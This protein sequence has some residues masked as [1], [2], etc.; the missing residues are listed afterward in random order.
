MGGIYLDEMYVGRMD[1]F[2]LQF[3]LFLVFYLGKVV[4]ELYGLFFG[5]VQNLIVIELVF[6][7]CDILDIV[8]F[9]K[10]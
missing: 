6:S 5:L 9:I 7:K 2:V 3:V 4:E 10:Q 8:L 1:L